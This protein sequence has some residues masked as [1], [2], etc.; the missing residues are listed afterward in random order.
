M[1][2]GL[3]LFVVVLAAVY[4]SAHLPLYHFAVRAFAPSAP[5]L[6]TLRAFFAAS[7]LLFLV[8]RVTP[9]A[10]KPLAVWADVWFGT[11]FIAFTFWLLFLVPTLLW[12]PHARAFDIAALALTAIAAAVSLVHNALPPQVKVVDLAIPGAPPMTVAHLSDVHLNRWTSPK[13]VER[14]ADRTL[15]AKPDLI[16]ITGDLVDERNG[17]LEFLIPSLRRLRAPLGVWAVPGNHEFYTGLDRAGDLVTRAG[18]RWMRNERADLPNGWTVAGL[19][20][21]AGRGMG[22]KPA[23]TP[24]AFFA[25]LP[26]DRPVL[27]LYHPPRAFDLARAAG[28]KLQLSGHLHAGQIPPLDAIIFAFFEYPY[29]LY[30]EGD[31][32]LYTTSGAGTWGPPMRLFVGSEIPVFRINNRE[33]LTARQQVGGDR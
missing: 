18:F 19:D 11:V 29:G 2:L 6:W 27:F 33:G 24:K 16:A 13:Q 7:G 25:G 15:A 22:M 31:A 3:L 4:G 17:G 30:R 28:V 21:P 12:R 8:V 20:D 1:R 9:L 32:Y 10:W 26:P 5:W 14:L 23:V